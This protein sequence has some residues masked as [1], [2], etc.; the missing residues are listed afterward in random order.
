MFL[1]ECGTCLA[2]AGNRDTKFA[3]VAVGTCARAHL[4]RDP[5]RKRVESREGKKR[6]AAA[7]AARVYRRRDNRDG[8][9]G[10]ARKGKERDKLEFMVIPSIKSIQ[11]AAYVA[12]DFRPA[13][14]TRR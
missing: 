10:L 3:F 5:G 9:T 11:R 6:S 1:L 12:R 14:R 13:T 2:C 7:N 4:G 8:G